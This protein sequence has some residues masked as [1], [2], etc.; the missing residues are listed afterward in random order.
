MLHVAG[1]KE[2]GSVEVGVFFFEDVRQPMR[3]VEDRLALIVVINLRD[4]VDSLCDFDE[5]FLAH[6]I[7]KRP[8]VVEITP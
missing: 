2:P 6:Y 5:V 4:F 7:N 8:A 1:C 3:H